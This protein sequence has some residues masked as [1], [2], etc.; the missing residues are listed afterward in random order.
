[1]RHFRALHIHLKFFQDGLES[2]LIRKHTYLVLGDRFARSLVL[3]YFKGRETSHLLVLLTLS[4]VSADELAHPKEILLVLQNLIVGKQV[5]IAWCR[6]E[7]RSEK[8]FDAAGTFR[9]GRCTTLGDGLLA[10]LFD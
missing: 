4:Y 3:V 10:L 9:L 1:M 7:T 2:Q 8:S 6:K 5:P